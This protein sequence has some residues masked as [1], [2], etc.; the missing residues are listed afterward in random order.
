MELNAKYFKKAM[1]SDPRM[2][3][4]CCKLVVPIGFVARDLFVH[5]TSMLLCNATALSIV[6]IPVFIS[7]DPS[8]QRHM[9]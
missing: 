5:S 4:Q 7:F 1:K 2:P 8:N 3:L 6:Q 9:P